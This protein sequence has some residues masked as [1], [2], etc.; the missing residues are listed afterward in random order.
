MIKQ[1]KGLWCEIKSELYIKLRGR[2]NKP[3]T[4]GTAATILIKTNILLRSFISFQSLLLKI[5]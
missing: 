5:P 2:E 1:N 4:D 3:D